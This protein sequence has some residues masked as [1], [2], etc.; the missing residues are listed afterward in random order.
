MDDQAGRSRARLH[1]LDVM[2]VVGVLIA[3]KRKGFVEA[4]RPLFDKMR[5]CD[6]HVSDKVIQDALDQVG[7]TRETGVR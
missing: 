1:Q 5:E 6:F 3:A 7:E 2:T 4:I